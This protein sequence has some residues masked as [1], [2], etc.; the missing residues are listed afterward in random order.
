MLTVLVPSFILIK[1]RELVCFPSTSFYFPSCY[2]VKPC[3]QITVAARQNADETLVLCMYFLPVW[4][5][6]CIRSWSIDSFQISGTSKLLLSQLRAGTAVWCCSLSARLLSTVMVISLN[7][8]CLFRS[9]PHTFA[10][11]RCNMKTIYLYGRCFI[12]GIASLVKCMKCFK[13]VESFGMECS[14]ISW[15][16][17]FLSK[18]GMCIG[19][20]IF[21]NS[22]NKGMWHTVLSTK[23]NITGQTPVTTTG[24]RLEEWKERMI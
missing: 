8:C 22:W 14:D 3:I 9:F 12:C 1:F 10:F 7:N 19:C 2:P 23:L 16:P 13:N 21:Q 18:W 5:W 11:I 17:N 4:Y 20:L 24:K 6:W 15:T